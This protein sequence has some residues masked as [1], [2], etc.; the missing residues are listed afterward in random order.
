M[1]SYDVRS[2]EL[3]AWEVETGLSLPLPVGEI[4]AIEDAGGIVDLLSGEVWHQ[5]TLV[6]TPVLEAMVVIDAMEQP[7]G[8]P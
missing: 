8:N 3:L 1:A 5:L 2:G 6:S 7:H 4:L